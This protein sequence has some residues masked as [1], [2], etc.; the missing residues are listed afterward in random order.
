MGQLI[1]VVG[2]SGVGKTTLTG[3]L[4]GRFGS[5]IGLEQLEER[6]FQRP[7]AAGE[8][9]YALANQVDYL[10]FRAEQEEVIRR[11]PGIGIQDGGLD[12]DFQL[13]TRYFF[14]KGY[15]SAAEFDLCGRFYAFSR[16]H[17]PLPDLFVV[18]SAPLAVIE[19][20][21]V[22][23]GRQVEIA[24]RED[25]AAME[26]LFQGWI[27]AL[28]PQ[29]VIRVD[30]GDDHYASLANLAELQAVNNGRLA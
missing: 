22:A 28:D 29:R 6:P 18:M 2:N 17:L 20:R 30:A 5:Q 16:R 19:A 13:F 14:Q 27:T 9:R 10:L 4:A 23:R 21:H 24:H 8:A 26:A 3:H 12:L 15:L 1:A 11:A 25:L 7:F